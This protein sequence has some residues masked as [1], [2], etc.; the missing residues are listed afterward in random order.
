MA[1][2]LTFK[3]SVWRVNSEQFYCLIHDRRTSKS[4]L[5]LATK[6]DKVVYV[7]PTGTFPDVRLLYPSTREVVPVQ[8][9]AQIMAYL[10]GRELIWA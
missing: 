4:V 1:H 8:C 6:P 3:W 9:R 7:D 2:S 10:T 5:F